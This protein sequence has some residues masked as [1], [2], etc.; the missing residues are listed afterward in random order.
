M[1]QSFWFTR[2]TGSPRTHERLLRN[3]AKRGCSVT[4][5]A[6]GSRTKVGVC[7][8]CG[9]RGAIIFH[10]SSACARFLQVKKLCLAGMS[11][12]QIKRELR[13]LDEALNTARDRLGLEL[14]GPK[15]ET[16]R[17]CGW[18]GWPS[19]FKSNE[20]PCARN[21]EIKKMYAAGMPLP[22]IGR[23]LGMDSSLVSRAL[24]SL[25]VKRRPPIDH[26]NRNPL[27]LNGR[28]NRHA[29]YSRGS[30][31]SKTTRE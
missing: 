18:R 22:A 20:H 7:Q 16:C 26:H 13:I 29:D 23:K 24:K 12:R 17:L 4:T 21:L 30:I 11:R 31:R 14:P 8:V 3:G 15:A 1:L 19:H 25:G 2:C 9:W 10:S 6:T 28:Q 27:G 5:D